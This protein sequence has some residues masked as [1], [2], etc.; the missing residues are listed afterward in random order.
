MFEQL[1]R[2]DRSDEPYLYG[3]DETVS[4]MSFDALDADP[5]IDTVEKSSLLYFIKLYR[6]GQLN[7]TPI[8]ATQAE[9]KHAVL[10]H[11]FDVGE[12]SS[13]FKERVGQANYWS[14]SKSRD[15]F[16]HSVEPAIAA[17]VVEF[18]ASRDLIECFI[19]SQV[20][21]RKSEGI[22]TAEFL[23]EVGASDFVS[24]FSERVRSCLVNWFQEQRSTDSARS[25]NIF[26]VQSFLPTLQIRICDTFMLVPDLSRDFLTFLYRDLLHFFKNDGEFRGSWGSLDMLPDK[27][28]LLRVNQLNVDPAGKAKRAQRIE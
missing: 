19:K 9:W 15:L 3:E 4:E 28:F 24:V 16:S 21:L 10:L 17:P 2:Q 27:T 12:L 1:L 25:I 20:V 11:H 22:S 8:I 7:S 26:D 5:Q 23:S 14:Q 18:R 6:Q 13:S